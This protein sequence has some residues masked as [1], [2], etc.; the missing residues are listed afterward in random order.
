M[1]QKKNILVAP[2]HW[3]LGHAT[4]CI[5]IIRS[6]LDNGFDV[7]LASDGAALKLLEIEFPDLKSYELPSY[8]IRYARKGGLL[9]VKLLF[10]LPKIRKAISEEK[11]I[12][13]RLVRNG[14]IDG[15][16]SDNRFGVYSK[17]VPSVFITHQLNVLSGNTTWLSSKA[18][19]RVIRKFT[20][21][22]VPDIEGHGNLS[23][24]LGHLK[25][26]LFKLRYIGPL[27]RMIPQ[28]REIKYELLC[29]L[30]G[31]EP[32]RSLLEETLMQ[33]LRHAGKRVIMVR[34]VVE[35]AVR[36]EEHDGITLVN[37]LPSRELEKVIN[38]SE[39]VLS[40][41]GYTTIM[42]LAV[43][44]KKAFFIPTPGQYEQKYL[45][46]RLAK[47]KLVPFCKQEDFN[48]SKLEEI[49]MFKGLKDYKSNVN[50]G[51]LFH[52]FERE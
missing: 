22:W 49:S 2:L 12:V 26:P 6:L 33:Q 25:R 51:N 29:L 37:F 52:L 20:E 21:C 19:Q 32:Q 44:G 42:D 41:S 36:K 3:G 18:H 43:L 24:K 31:P 27:S 23:G 13:K 1:K 7:T 39:I 28:E 10:S 15:I 4:R 35:D 5:P 16:I 9:K 17:K 40:R 50:L 11:K 8:D 30:S 34:G 45:A 48:I 47:N 46:E 14:Y 38:E